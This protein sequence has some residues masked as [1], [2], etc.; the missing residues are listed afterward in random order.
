MFWCGPFRLASRKKAADAILNR[1]RP[2]E[3]FSLMIP[4]QRLL[5]LQTFPSPA[6]E[7]PKWFALREK[8]ASTGSA[9]VRRSLYFVNTPR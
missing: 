2:S 5:P 3:S 6:E 4:A 9:G 1:R 7:D 8:K